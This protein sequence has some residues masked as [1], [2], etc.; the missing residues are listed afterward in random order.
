M[1]RALINYCFF[2]QYMEKPSAIK[3]KN[4]VCR[5]GGGTFY[6]PCDDDE[7]PVWLDHLS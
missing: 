1:A 2:K 7:K 4:R 5:P 6:L 3:I